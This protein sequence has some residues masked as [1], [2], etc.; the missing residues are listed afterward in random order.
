M[1]QRPK[2]VLVRPWRQLEELE[3]TIRQVA[4]NTYVT[5]RQHEHLITKQNGVDV[6]ILHIKVYKIKRFVWQRIK[7]CVSEARGVGIFIINT[8]CH[9]VHV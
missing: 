8:T 6:L 3:S 4:W 7:Y 2:Y 5:I 1:L 9:T